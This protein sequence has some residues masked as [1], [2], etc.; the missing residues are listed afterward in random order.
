MKRCCLFL[1][2]V[3]VQCSTG[4]LGVFSHWAVQGPWRCQS[5]QQLVLHRQSLWQSLSILPASWL[6]PAHLLHLR[7]IP[8]SRW[9]LD[10][11]AESERCW[12]ELDP[13][14]KTR[15]SLPWTAS[16]SDWCGSAGPVWF[17]WILHLLCQWPV[18]ARLD[19]C[20]LGITGWAGSTVRNA[21]CT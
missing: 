19:A 5:P 20:Q 7:L 3:I 15:W 1:M 10:R 9:P 16:C 21:I 14:N 13:W 4:I 8:S 17:R 6:Q 2:N 12:A 11:T 18:H